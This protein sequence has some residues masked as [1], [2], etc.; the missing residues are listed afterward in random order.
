MTGRKEQKIMKPRSNENLR[1]YT[2]VYILYYAITDDN[3]QW[4]ATLLFY[5]FQFGQSIYLHIVQESEITPKPKT[6]L[7][8][9]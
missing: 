1:L 9:K 4:L 2:Y 5:I 6:T 7:G 3:D 8:R